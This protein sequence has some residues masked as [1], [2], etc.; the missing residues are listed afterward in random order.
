MYAAGDRGCVVTSAYYRHSNHMLGPALARRPESVRAVFW[1]ARPGGHQ[2][3]NSVGA[4]ESSGE[5]V[6][7]LQITFNHLHALIGKRF[8]FL[9]IA[10]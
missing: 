2:H 3:P 6:M 9:P 5:C 7:K 1:R 4:I 8:C 10:D